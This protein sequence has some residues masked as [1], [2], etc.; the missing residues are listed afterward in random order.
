MQ[1]D[2]NLNMVGWANRQQQIRKLYR[3]LNYKLYLAC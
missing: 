1:M 2:F 3:I